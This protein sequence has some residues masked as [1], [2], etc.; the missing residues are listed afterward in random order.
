MRT[1]SRMVGSTRRTDRNSIRLSIRK[2]V[3]DTG[4]STPPTAAVSL[5]RHRSPKI[6]KVS[7]PGDDHVIGTLNGVWRKQ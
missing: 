3:G 6:P 7:I 4:N 1:N 2:D 5:L